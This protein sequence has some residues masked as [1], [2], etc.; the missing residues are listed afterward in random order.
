M[1]LA[2]GHRLGCN[3]DPNPVRQEDH[4]VPSARSIL[5]IRAAGVAAV[6]RTTISPQAITT[7]DVTSARGSGALGS[8]TGATTKDYKTSRPLMSTSGVDKPF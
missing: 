7:C 8:I 1:T 4:G 3:N 2:E 5:A 6:R